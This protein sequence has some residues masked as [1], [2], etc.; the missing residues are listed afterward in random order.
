MSTYNASSEK[1]DR[2]ECIKREYSNPRDGGDED[3]RET[4]K[5]VE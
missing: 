1:E 3:R 2:S 4:N 5:C